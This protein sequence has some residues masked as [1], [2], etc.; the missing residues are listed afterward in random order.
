MALKD[1]IANV[2]HLG[3]FKDKWVNHPFPYMSEAN[4]AMCLLTEHNQFSEDHIAK[5]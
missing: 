1:N 5:L 4:K 3:K 2:K